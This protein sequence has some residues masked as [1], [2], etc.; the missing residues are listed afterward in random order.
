[1]AKGGF[2]EEPI[3]IF[4]LLVI[5]LFL[6]WYAL[7]RAPELRTDQVKTIVGESLAEAGVRSADTITKDI[8]QKFNE[9]QVIQSN[10]ESR[11]RN[12]NELCGDHVCTFAGVRF[13]IAAGQMTY[14]PIKCDLKT[15]EALFCNCCN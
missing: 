3:G 9:C 2:K 14:Q 15:S 5:I 1:M 12:C 6:G 8:F 7:W 11:D 10:K 4:A 13:D